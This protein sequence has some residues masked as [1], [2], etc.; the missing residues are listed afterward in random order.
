[1]ST[2]RRTVCSISARARSSRCGQPAGQPRELGAHDAVGH[3]AQRDDGRGDARGALPAEEGRDLVGDDR[4]GR[5]DVGGVL[6]VLEH[7]GQRLE[8][9]DRHPGEVA[10][11]RVDVAGQ[12]QVE[13]DERPA[14]AAAAG[15]LESAAATTWPT[16]PVHDTTRS[17]R[18]QRRRAPRPAARP[19]RRRSAATRSA[20]DRVRLATTMRPAPSWAS[21]VA[22][23]ALI[24][25]APTTRADAAGQRADDA[26]AASSR[27]AV[28]S[29]RPARSMPV[30]VRARLP[31]RSA[32]WTSAAEDAP[33][34][35]GVLRQPQRHADLAE[36][37]A[38]ADDHRVQAAGDREQV[39]D[40]AVLVVH[41]EV[42]RQVVEG[43]A[44][45]AGE[46]LGG[47]RPA[48]PWNLSTS[49]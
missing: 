35:A 23:S 49:A 44:G 3:V 11:P 46:Q 32:C 1:M 47:L 19:C 43:D 39:G 40:G 10:G 5:L 22:D 17:A 36:D 9:D 12:G 27:P 2:T 41:V 18:R 4:P 34:G 33:G 13:H 31:T 14:V 38:L 26:P 8:V 7:L 20:W 48:P 21:T 16:A 37:L 6:G 42:R 30:S 45:V 29:E 15:G 25:P 24:E 28:T